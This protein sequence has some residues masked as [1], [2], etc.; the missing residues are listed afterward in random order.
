MLESLLIGVVC[1]G[2]EDE[3]YKFYDG[4]IT[5]VDDIIDRLKA[6]YTRR[7]HSRTT[8]EAVRQGIRDVMRGAVSELTEDLLDDE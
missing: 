1:S 8:E 3:D 6:E 4:Y 2:S 7:D 5:A